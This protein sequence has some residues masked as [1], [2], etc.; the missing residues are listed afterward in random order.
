MEVHVCKKDSSIERSISG[1][2]L[3]VRERGRERARDRET[4]SATLSL[5][6]IPEP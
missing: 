3:M 1:P 4:E 2:L 5:N 6:I